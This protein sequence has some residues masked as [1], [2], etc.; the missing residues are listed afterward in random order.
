MLD[1]VGN[2]KKSLPD[3][4][5]LFSDLELDF[6]RLKTSEI[7]AASAKFIMNDPT[8][9]GNKVAIVMKTDED[10]DIANRWKRLTEPASTAKLSIFRSERK[11][12]KWLARAA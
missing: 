2:L 8:L 7:A 12:M 10:Y 5:I 9:G 3:R 11:A 1:D 6:G 4:P